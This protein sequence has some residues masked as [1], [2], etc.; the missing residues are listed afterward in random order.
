MLSEQE[1]LSLRY[2]AKADRPLWGGH[3]QRREPISDPDM[4]SWIERG[5]IKQV[6]DQGYIIT[7]AGRLA[8]GR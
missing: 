4:R 3:L 1:R 2:L 7:D 5:L 6:E 8:I